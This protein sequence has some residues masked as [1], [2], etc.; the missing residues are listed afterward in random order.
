MNEKPVLDSEAQAQS[1][2]TKA[3]LATAA[4]EA[5]RAREALG[6]VMVGIDE[7]ASAARCD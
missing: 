7:R 4:S 3:E 6:C 2:G 5:R 1:A